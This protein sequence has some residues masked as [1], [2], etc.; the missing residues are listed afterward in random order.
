MGYFE[1]TFKKLLDQSASAVLKILIGILIIVIGFKVVK[2]ALKTIKKGKGYA[3]LE[4]SLASFLISFIGITLRILILITAAGEMGLPITSLVT[5]LASAG[6]AIGLALQ[7]GLSNLAGGVMLLFFRPFK[8]GDYIKTADGE[9]TVVE[10]TVFYTHIRTYDNRRIT[11]PNGG[12][13]AAA[14]TNY[15]YEAKRRVDLSVS[16]AYNSDLQKVQQTILQAI[17]DVPD[18]LKDPA[19]TCR[20]DKMGDSALEFIVK[21][22]CPSEKY[23]EVYYTLNEN[24]KKALDDNSIAIPYPQLDV[25]IDRETV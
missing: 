22:W 9:G 3:K 25:H 6:V 23:W 19:P 17:S 5:V 7:G 18:V 1:E 4:P 14:I 20:L 16:V 21:S 24:I 12:L 13:T 2:W 11:L 10:I 15:T 8:I